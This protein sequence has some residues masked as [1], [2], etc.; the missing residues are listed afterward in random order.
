MQITVSKWGNSLAVRIPVEVAREL[1][2]ADGTQVE[3]SISASGAIELKP[4]SNETDSD[5]LKAHF[6]AV[7]KRLSGVKVT[8]PTY[9][10]LKENERY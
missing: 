9:I 5:W 1:N 3:C 8:T 2:L 10:L 6:A 4:P 7:N